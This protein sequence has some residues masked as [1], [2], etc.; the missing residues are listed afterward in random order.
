M[1]ATYDDILE[2]AKSIKDEFPSISP[3]DLRKALQARF[4]QGRDLLPHLEQTP[5]GCICPPP[6]FYP[7]N[8]LRLVVLSIRKVFAQDKGKLLR[9]Q[10]EIDRV[11][12]L[13]SVIP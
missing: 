12:E 9:L 13:L 2:Y 11:V 10:E 4:I 1:N 8:L 5:T 3:D 6:W 7:L